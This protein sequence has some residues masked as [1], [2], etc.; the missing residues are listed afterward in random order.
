M[1]WEGAA[2]T[3]FPF[4]LC[5]VIEVLGVYAPLWLGGDI[6]KVRGPS[7]FPFPINHPT[8]DSHSEDF[9][10][11]NKTLTSFSILHEEGN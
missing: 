4:N 10:K 8:P 6:I 1:G 9:L 7:I 2:P 11:N 5:Q 3:Q